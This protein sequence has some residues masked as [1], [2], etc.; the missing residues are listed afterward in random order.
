MV[1]NIELTYCMGPSRYESHRTKTVISLIRTSVKFHMVSTEP[2]H[3]YLLLLFLVKSI[4]C[5]EFFFWVKSGSEPTG[6]GFCLIPGT[7]EFYCYET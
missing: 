4:I 5:I 7:L 1:T 6:N 3:E 2:R